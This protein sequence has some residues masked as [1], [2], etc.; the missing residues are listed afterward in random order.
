VSKEINSDHLVSVSSNDAKGDCTGPSP[1]Q[2]A[3]VIKY[4]KQTPD[5]FSRHPDVL[6][7][8]ELSHAGGANSVSLIE[9]Q[10]STLREQNSKLENTLAEFIE[11]ARENDKLIEKIHRLAV[12]LIKARHL[13]GVFSVIE[14]SLRSDFGVD[15][16]SM[17]VYR[18]VTVSN[19]TALSG[20]F[21]RTVKRDDAELHDLFS[22]VLKT[23]KPRCGH[24]KVAQRDYLFREKAG[25]EVTSAALVPLG[26][27]GEVGLL[28]FG[29][30]DMHHFN[31]S[32]STDFL[33]RIGE[34]VSQVIATN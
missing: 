2:E 27:D 15:V 8:L 4:L 19:I 22:E 24:L 20:S 32:A 3:P 21:G 1:A 18:D 30:F 14:S 17:L 28:A 13:P 29:S 6:S 7:Q 12:K 26:R 25:K 9:R 11:V 23:G 33:E 34:L 16:F 10:V 5:F 31:P